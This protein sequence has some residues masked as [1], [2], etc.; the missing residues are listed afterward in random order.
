[1]GY[2]F[3]IYLDKASEWRW[4]LQSIGNRKIIADSGEGYKNRADCEHGVQLVKKYGPSATVVAGS[5]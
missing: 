2:Q 1:M 3:V 4:Q 5:L